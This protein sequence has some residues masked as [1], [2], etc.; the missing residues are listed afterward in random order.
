M[1]AV[2]T[3][4]RALLLLYRCPY[5]PLEGEDVMSAMLRVDLLNHLSMA[6]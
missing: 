1:R 6:Y 5:S 4:D 2:V 3:K